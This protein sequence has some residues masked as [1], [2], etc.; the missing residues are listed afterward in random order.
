MHSVV[1]FPQFSRLIAFQN[2]REFECLSVQHAQMF[3]LFGFFLLTNLLFLS[4][5]HAIPIDMRH[6][7]IP[8]NLRNVASNSCFKN[9]FSNCVANVRTYLHEYS[10]RKH[11]IFKKKNTSFYES[12]SIWK[13][14]SQGVFIEKFS[15]QLT[16]FKSRFLFLLFPS[17]FAGGLT[18]TKNSRLM[19]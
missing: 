5:C 19:N 7:K 17:H 16:Y 3:D 18:P 13:K 2:V 1:F 4:C 12:F 6:P 10:I 14:S 8:I 15:M 11:R 9:D